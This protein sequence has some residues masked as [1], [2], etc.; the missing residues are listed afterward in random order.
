MAAILE[1]VLNRILKLQFCCQVV[2]TKF[3]ILITTNQRKKG[4]Q[5]YHKVHDPCSNYSPIPLSTDKINKTIYRDD[6][7]VKPITSAIKWNSSYKQD[8]NVDLLSATYPGLHCLASPPER[9]IPFMSSWY[10][11]QFYLNLLSSN[12]HWG[13][14]VR[15]FPVIL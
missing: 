5:N 10:F 6:Y 11:Q 8:T 7:N 14:C 15:N 12:P 3:T 1:L 9:C 4:L 2:A 13:F